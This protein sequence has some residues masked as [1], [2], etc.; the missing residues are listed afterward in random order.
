[1]KGLP[2]WFGALKLTGCPV[3]KTPIA[4][5]VHP[6]IAMF[7]QPPFG[8][9][10]RNGNS[11]TALATARRRTSKLVGPLEHS[12]QMVIWFPLELADCQASESAFAQ[13]YSNRR[14]SP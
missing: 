10:R 12:R 11:Q 1:M 7:A 3:E 4:D 14:F 9:P 6:L 2:V 8:R 13:V 5:T